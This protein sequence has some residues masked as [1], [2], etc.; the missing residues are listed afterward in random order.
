MK[1]RLPEKL[2]N[3]RIRKG[4]YR[5]REGLHGA[6]IIYGP[7][8]IYLKIM[9]S[10]VDQEFGWEHVSVSVR[11]RCPNWEEMTYVKQLFWNPEEA[12]MQLHPPESDY[13]NCHPHC[14]HMWRPL[15]A[16]IP[17]PPSGLVG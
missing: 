14:L 7:C 2:E 8:G 4:P 12:V 5:S 1:T 9:S 3:G 16:E 15:R 6:F 13:V 10:G 17:L 11:H